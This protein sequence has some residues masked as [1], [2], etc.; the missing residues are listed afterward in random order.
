MR[1]LI[2]LIAAM[3]LILSLPLGVFATSGSFVPS[4]TYKEGPA[5]QEVKTETG[6]AAVGVVVDKQGNTSSYV[7][8]ECLV[9]TPISAMILTK[10]EVITPTEAP[11]TEETLAPGETAA[12][13]E[14]EAT[15]VTE[16]TV[17]SAVSEETAQLL[18]V[19]VALEE[20][21]MEIPYEKIEGV[22]EEKAEKM[23]VLD[24]ASVTWVCDEVNCQHDHK[25]AV[26]EEG[27]TFQVTF[28]LGV[29][30]DTEIYAM[31]YK[32]DEWN[33]IVSTVN[34][35]DGTVT[36]VFEHL[37]PVAFVV[38]SD[39]LPVPEETTAPAVDSDHQEAAPEAPAVNEAEAES[40]SG[41]GGWAAL[42]AAAAAALAVVVGK[43]KKK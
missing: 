5:V 41:V 21:T 3:M 31:T 12:T 40:K 29:A 38:N 7:E 9:I 26:E 4:V 39:T 32:N 15:E 25:G 10:P 14:T 17:P 18:E 11:A 37:C 28:D 6:S 42:M 13:E 20:G 35:G 22:D 23:V 19:Y 24:L 16:A 43:K 8:K 27:V 1:K 36:C 30:P 33:P 34:N 2:C